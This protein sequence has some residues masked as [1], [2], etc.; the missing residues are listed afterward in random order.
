MA[1]EYDLP[2]YRGAALD[3]QLILRDADTKAAIDLTG[4]AFRGQIRENYDI[5]E[6][7]GEFDLTVNDPATDGVVNI[8]MSLDDVL[9]I[10]VLPAMGFPA[11]PTSY[12]Y[13]IIGYPP[14]SGPAVMIVR[15]AALVYPGATQPEDT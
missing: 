13:D 15:G 9:S 11:P 3:E 1:I 6:I 7:L 5:E 10:P 12:C 8:A 4:W 2:I 14:E